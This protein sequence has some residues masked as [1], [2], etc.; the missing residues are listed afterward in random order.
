M[1]G[2]FQLPQLSWI[3][4]VVVIG[5][6]GFI[7]YLGSSFAKRQKT[8]DHFFAGGRHIPSW[9]VG[10][11]ILAT[12][13]SSVTF[14]AYPGEGYNENSMIRLVQGFMVPI[15]LICI[16]WF[17]VPMFRKVIG[18]STYEYF[19]KRFGVIPRFYT[20]I[21]FSLMHFAKMGTVFYLMALSIST[22]LCMS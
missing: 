14:L 3:D 9:A 12:L 22:F 16:V 1:E 19:E 11:S 5:Y 7:T 2:S 6:L 20:S 10:L 15:V 4:Y 21:S 13:I 17:V 8:T 18:I